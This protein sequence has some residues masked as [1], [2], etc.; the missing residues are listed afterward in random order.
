MSTAWPTINPFETAIRS[1]MRNL[2]MN[3]S[4]LATKAAVPRA[5]LRRRLVD[6]PSSRLPEIFDLAT[7]LE[8]DVAWLAGLAVAG[9]QR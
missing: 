6:P 4:Q 3:E 8:V 2:G 1:R 9:A 7:A 5:T